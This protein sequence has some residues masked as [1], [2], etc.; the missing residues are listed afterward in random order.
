MSDT[1]FTHGAHP[2]DVMSSCI[3]E[4]TWGGRILSKLPFDEI[5]CRSSICTAIVSF[6]EDVV[7]NEQ[8]EFFARPMQTVF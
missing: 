3:A 1:F 6:F 4:V 5:Q 2:S 7:L 8:P